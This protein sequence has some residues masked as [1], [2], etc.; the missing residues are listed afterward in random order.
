MEM[1]TSFMEPFNY[2]SE[3]QQVEI[4]TMKLCSWHSVSSRVVNS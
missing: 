2:V 1:F 3:K 4:F